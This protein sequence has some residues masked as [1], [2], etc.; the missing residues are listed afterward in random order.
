MGLAEVSQGE[1]WFAS[2]TGRGALRRRGALEQ[3]CV[4]REEAETLYGSAAVSPAGRQALTSAPSGIFSAFVVCCGALFSELHHRRWFADGERSEESIFLLSF[5]SSGPGAGSQ[6]DGKT[7]GGAA[8]Q[9]GWPLQTCSLLS[10]GLNCFMHIFL[11]LP[12]A[13]SP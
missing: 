6:M 11:G 4:G 5:L 3:D 12:S 10:K 2:K 8:D 9:V 13:P 1:G 7:R